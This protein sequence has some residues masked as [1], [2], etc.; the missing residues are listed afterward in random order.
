VIKQHRRGAQIAPYAAAATKNSEMH[1]SVDPQGPR[2]AARDDERVRLEIAAALRN[3]RV[4]ALP[5][6]QID[7]SRTSHEVTTEPTPGADGWTRC[8]L[9]ESRVDAEELPLSPTRE[10][11]RNTVAHMSIISEQ[12]DDGL[13][14]FTGSFLKVNQPARG[15]PS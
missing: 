14:G 11:Q 4:Q 12:I 3:R 15:V 9:S 8:Q 1:L 5:L 6:A 10:E 7:E 13:D 2:F